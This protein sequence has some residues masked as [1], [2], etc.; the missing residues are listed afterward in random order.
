MRWVLVLDIM[1]VY[2]IV[3]LRAEPSSSFNF[4]DIVS[5]RNEI[6]LKEQIIKQLISVITH[7]DL[8]SDGNGE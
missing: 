3:V 2:S 6:L 7:T 8:F 5:L 4:N 1:I